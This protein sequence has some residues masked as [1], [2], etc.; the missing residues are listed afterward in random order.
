[1]SRKI[2]S[3]CK[4]RKN[5]K[6]FPKHSHNKDNIDTRCR[7]CIRKHNKIRSKLRTKAPEKPEVC[8]CC[9]KVPKKWCLDHDHTD[10]SFRGWLCNDCNTGIGNLGDNIEGVIKAINYLLLVRSRKS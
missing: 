1:M 10:N 8:E 2:C 7:H 3:Y 9:K 5:R 4:K 6:S